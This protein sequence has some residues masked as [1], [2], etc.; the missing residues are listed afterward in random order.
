VKQ[1]NKKPLTFLYDHS[2]VGLVVR[3]KQGYF[4]SELFYF[5]RFSEEIAFKIFVLLWCFQVIW[6][7]LRRAVDLMVRNPKIALKKAH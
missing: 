2:F 1:Q 3:D 4:F 5:F 7:S 6:S